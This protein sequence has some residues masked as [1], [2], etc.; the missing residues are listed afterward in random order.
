MT[1]LEHPDVR[2][3]GAQQA[4]AWFARHFGMMESTALQVVQ[5]L[6]DEAAALKNRLTAEAAFASRG[7]DQGDGGRGNEVRRQL[8]ESMLRYG[9][10][11]A[12][13]VAHRCV[14]DM[15]RK[16]R[17]QMAAVSGDFASLRN[18]LGQLATHFD[19]LDSTAAGRDS[20]PGTRAAERGRHLPPP[21]DNGRSSQLA[22]MVERQLSASLAPGDRSLFRLLTGALRDP[23]VLVKSL[24][25]AARH[26]LA[27][28]A[29]SKEAPPPELSG[30]ADCCA[31]DSL[32]A[33]LEESTPRLLAC[34]GAKRVLALVPRDAHLETLK[35]KLEPSLGAISVQPQEEDELVLCC[36]AERIPLD[37]VAASLIAGR[38]EY[39]D[40]AARLHTRVDVDWPVD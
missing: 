33:R 1:R 29:D 40:L 2:L 39:V 11:R 31:A 16:M 7:E 26:V 9:Q 20:K 4:T 23:D 12:Y 18:K 3:S 13:E 17:Q 19:A 30:S 27:E 15:A 36:E 14:G 37:N 34:G 22:E 32:P 28:Q 6:S 24:R 5:R 25:A 8:A 10:L 38:Q 21:G 35:R